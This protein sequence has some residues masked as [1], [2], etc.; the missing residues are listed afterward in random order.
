MTINC[1][2]PVYNKG[3]NM[4]WVSVLPKAIDDKK[5]IASGL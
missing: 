4:F 1:E 2:K 5:D 3:Y